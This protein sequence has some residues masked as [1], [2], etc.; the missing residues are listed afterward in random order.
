MTIITT[1]TITATIIISSSPT[2]TATP[3]TRAVLLPGSSMASIVSVGTIIV[4]DKSV[5][6]VITV[7]DNIIIIPIE[8]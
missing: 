6:D 3:A 1:V 2:P 7:D 4:V 5:V 8:R